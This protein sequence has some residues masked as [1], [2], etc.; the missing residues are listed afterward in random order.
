MCVITNMNT[1]EMVSLPLQS[2]LLSQHMTSGPP[3]TPAHPP[4]LQPDE[5]QEESEL[6][7]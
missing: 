6:L 7:P 4:R 2:L 1:V 5:T 3:A